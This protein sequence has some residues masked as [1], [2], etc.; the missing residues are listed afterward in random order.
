M[1]GHTQELLQERTSPLNRQQERHLQS[2]FR[3]IEDHAAPL[4]RRMHQ[5]QSTDLS[6]VTKEYAEQYIDEVK[7]AISEMNSVLHDMEPVWWEL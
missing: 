4:S 6:G 7:N 5:L 2:I 3:H 1:L